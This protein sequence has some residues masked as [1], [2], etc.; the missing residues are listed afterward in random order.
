[1]S[2]HQQHHTSICMSPDLHTHL[3]SRRPWGVAWKKLRGADATAASRVSCERTAALTPPYAKLNALACADS[4]QH[5]AL[6]PLWC[7][8][9]QQGAKACMSATA[10]QSRLKAARHT[11]ESCSL[12][13]RLPAPTRVNTVLRA[14]MAM[15]TSACSM[16]SA[17]IRATSLFCSS[18]LQAAA[19]WATSVGAA[20]QRRRLCWLT[21]SCQGTA[22]QLDGGARKGCAAPELPG[23]QPA[24][25]HSFSSSACWHLGGLLSSYNC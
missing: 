21:V 24:S 17:L 5:W 20:E 4:S 1:M 14:A 11:S 10:A 18:F 13:M 3:F 16:L 8:A 12:D 23:S 7:S 2:L 19:A 22:C 9:L 6:L 25:M 15:N